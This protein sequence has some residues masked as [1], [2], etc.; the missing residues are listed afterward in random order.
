VVPDTED[1]HFT[2][3]EQFRM[4]DLLGNEMTPKTIYRFAPSSV[5]GINNPI[6]IPPASAV[7]AIMACGNRFVTNDTNKPNPIGMKEAYDL[8]LARLKVGCICDNFRYISSV[9]HVL[10]T[11]R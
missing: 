8:S 7:L 9:S 2:T 5:P 1:L 4:T 6:L 11:T 10:R 3:K